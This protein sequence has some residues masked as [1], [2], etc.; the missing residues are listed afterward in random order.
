MLLL[1]IDI[2]VCVIKPSIA[3]QLYGRVCPARRRAPR[4]VHT[5]HLLAGLLG[6]GA[7]RGLAAAGRR[8]GLGR[9]AAMRAGGSTLDFLLLVTLTGVQLYVQRG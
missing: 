8:Q 2:I 5:C 1:F 3:V 9:G 7:G 6:L 4:C